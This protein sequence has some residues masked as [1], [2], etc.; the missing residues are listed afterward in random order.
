MEYALKQFCQTF[1]ENRLVF[2]DVTHK[3]AQRKMVLFEMHVDLH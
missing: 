2:R 3:H 1:S